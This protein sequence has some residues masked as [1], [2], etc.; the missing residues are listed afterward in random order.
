[1]SVVWLVVLVS[2]HPVLPIV[3]KLFVTHFEC[4][5]LGWRLSL[6]FE[7]SSRL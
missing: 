6:V 4:C 3:A 1:M 5:V 7:V 2:I